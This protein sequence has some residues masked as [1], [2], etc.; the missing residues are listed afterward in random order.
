MSARGLGGWLSSVVGWLRAGY[1]DGVPESD[2]VPLMA[3]LARR[4]SPDEVQTVA[5]ALTRSGDLPIDNI[6]IGT[7][8]TKIT[9]ELPREED[10]SR[11]R[12][13]LASGGW[14]LADP[15]TIR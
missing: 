14:P 9:A 8:I 4:L 1:P 12:A 3:V 5:S 13:R 2:Y 11:V 15:S 6:D 10:V 7:V